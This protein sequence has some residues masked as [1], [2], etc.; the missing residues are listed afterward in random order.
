MSHNAGKSNRQV[1]LKD[2]ASHA[3]VSVATVSNVVNN[4][5]PVSDDLKVKVQA[6]IKE[7]HY[8]PNYFAQLTR[9]QD[10]AKILG[11]IIPDIKNP[12]FSEV[13][14]GAEDSAFEV[15]YSVLICNSDSDYRKWNQ[16]V[17]MLWQKGIDGLIITGAWMQPREAHDLLMTKEIPAVLINYSSEDKNIDVVGVDRYMG[18][19]KI[20][21]YLYEAGHRNIGLVCGKVP[22]PSQ[23]RYNAVKGCKDYFNKRE[24]IPLEVSVDDNFTMRM[25]FHAGQQL[26]NRK[27]DLTAVFCEN[28]LLALG[29]IKAVTTAGFKVPED[30]SI[31]GADNIEIGNFISPTLT[32]IELNRYE[33]GMHA[34]RLL[35]ER[36]EDYS[37]YQRTILLR[38]EIL[39]RES[40][41][42]L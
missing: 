18:G 40:T 33:L 14:R 36:I 24:I 15:G 4:T 38:P 7:L 8:K 16:Y 21:E 19:Y 13:I 17:D 42:G 5:K 3:G 30:I 28:D 26:L 10:R 31:A 27:S 1:T 6:S 25:G 12:Y 23:E 29:V 20:G 2:V 35:L 22:T 32:T 37:L 11:F 9:K 39:L 34:V 41:R